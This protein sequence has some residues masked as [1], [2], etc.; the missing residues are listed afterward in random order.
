[1]KV[2]SKSIALLSKGC[3]LKCCR[4]GNYP[5]GKEIVIDEQSE[6]KAYVMS[7]YTLS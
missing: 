5:T 2:G 3:L 6:Q 7:V 1:M 4:D